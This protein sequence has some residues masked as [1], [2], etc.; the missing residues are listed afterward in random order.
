MRATKITCPQ[1]GSQSIAAVVGQAHGFGFVIETQ[2]GQDRP[3]HFL[4]RQGLLGPYLVEHGGLHIA[5][6]RFHLGA[7]TAQQQSGALAFGTRD[8]AHHLVQMRGI[9]QRAHRP[10][11]GGRNP[12]GSSVA[13]AAA[14]RRCSLPP[15]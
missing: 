10:P 12:R 4:A 1:A 11:P 9:D 3:E 5:A 8:I 15:G 7:M 2:H 14:N 6:A 13:P